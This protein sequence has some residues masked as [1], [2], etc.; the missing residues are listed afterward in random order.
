[1]ASIYRRG[2]TWWIRWYADGRKHWR[3]LKTRNK[4]IALYKKAQLEQE[5]AKGRNL[6]DGRDLTVAEAYQLYSK[7][8]QT[9]KRIKTFRN[10]SW[11]YKRILDLIGHQRLSWLTPGRVETCINDIAS[12][13][14]LTAT[15]RNHY[16]N[17]LRTMCRWLVLQGHLFDDPTR[18]V[19][20]VKATSHERVWMTPEV[21][22][23]FIALAQEQD[24]VHFPMIVVACLAGLRREEILT[25]EWEDVDFEHGVIRVRPKPGWSPK[26]RKGRII[27]LQRRLRTAL[28]PMAQKS[29]V[30]FP[31]PRWSRGQG[32]PYKTRPRDRVLKRLFEQVGLNGH[33][34]G[35]H[36]LRHTFVT[37]LFLAKPPIPPYKI[38]RWAGHADLRTTM[39]Y[40]HMVEQYDPDIEWEKDL[41]TVEAL[42]P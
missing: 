26:S 38:M 12:Q 31:T 20:R 42:R 11:Q 23:K 16:L 1:M 4:R 3:S 17:H 30:C 29:G 14:S 7:N 25:L 6:E 40:A 33:L 34:L 9:H 39:I 41:E 24:P 22:D 8:T 5:I 32:D 18:G 35:W 15:T 10:D 19:K 21:R 13:K 37:S 28:E 2:S 27:P 36:V